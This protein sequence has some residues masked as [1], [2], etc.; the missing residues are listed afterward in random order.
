MKERLKYHF[1]LKKGWL[2]DPNGPIWF[3]G[4]YHLYFQYNPYWPEF[5]GVHWGHAVSDDLITWEEMP[6][7]LFPDMP[8]EDQG[9][10]WSGSTLEYNGKIYAFYTGVSKQYGQAQ[11]MAW[12][13]DGVT[14]HKYEGNPVVRVAPPEGCH[15]FRDPK[16]F[17]YG[18][19]FCMLVASGRD[20]MARILKYDSADLM[21]WEYKGVFFESDKYNS[22]GEL[23]DFFGTIRHS[24]FECPDFFP[25]E[26]KYI[27]TCSLIYAPTHSTLFIYGDFDGDKFTPISFHNPEIG[28]DLY[29]T[30]TFAAPDGRRLA[31]GWLHHC[32]KTV[33]PGL[34]YAGAM[35]IPRELSFNKEGKLCMYPV[36]E[37]QHLLTH[38]GDMAILRD[39]R[40]VEIFFGDGETSIS[41]WLDE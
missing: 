27:L 12:S 31:I 21:N 19:K 2:N 24:H 26:G 38:C 20:K 5:K 32:W 25:F 34:P 10:C 3:N 23:P 4:K 30:Q 11:C 1:Q 40:T 15:E 29:A 35:S 22:H 41:T 28:P 33:T 9:G 36:R 17:Q 18:D 39:T 8:Y 7:A 13:E 6:P 14:F 16:V 37:A